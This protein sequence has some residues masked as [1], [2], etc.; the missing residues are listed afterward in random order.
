MKVSAVLALVYASAAYAS[1]Q[2]NANYALNAAAQKD[3]LGLLD[4][5]GV[6]KQIKCAGNCLG[7]SANKVYAKKGQGLTDAA[8]ENFDKIK[9][10]ALPCLKKCNVKESTIC[11]NPAGN[12]PPVSIARGLVKHSPLLTTLNHNSR[13]FQSSEA[14]L[15]EAREQGQRWQCQ[16]QEGRWRRL[17]GAPIGASQN[18]ALLINPNSL[19][20]SLQVLAWIP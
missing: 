20:R 7:D 16:E 8:C 12:F 14:V 19:F 4:T 15:Q 1:Y 13:S 11:K 10:G 3:I 5:L 2:Y 9:S 17:V 18:G 6:G